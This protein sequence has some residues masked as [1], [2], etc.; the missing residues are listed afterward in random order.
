MAANEDQ[1]DL[2]WPLSCQELIEVGG[3]EMSRPLKFG[4]LHPAAPARSLPA[5]RQQ[6]NEL[7]PFLRK[8][9]QSRP[10]LNIALFAQS[11]PVTGASCPV[12][13][14]PVMRVGS[15]NHGQTEQ[16]PPGVQRLR[17]DRRDACGP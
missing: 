10:T 17:Q 15:P 14:F 3:G 6:M 2:H 9:P 4:G 8:N 16:A 11:G 13:V 1:K 12:E 5:D 7:S